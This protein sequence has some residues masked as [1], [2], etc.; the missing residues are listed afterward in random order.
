MKYIPSIMIG[1]SIVLF[2]PTAY[3]CSCLS[4][5]RS[6]VQLSNRSDLVIRGKVMEYRWH[7]ND[8]AR[9]GRPLA[10]T[11][12][13]KEV[14]KG[15]T[16]LGKVTVWGDNGM[17][18]RPYVTQFPI[19]TEWI[20]ALSKDSWTEKGALAISVCGEH[21]LQVKG[22]NVVGK[23]T[24]GSANAKLNVMSFPDFRK[25]LKTAI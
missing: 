7:K 1:L 17:Q 19:G 23:V 12:E 6:F 10:M 21:W 8:P 24:N 4:R 13:V 15:G 14:Y 2:T 22:N 9:Q 16:K 3:A 25:L 5:D 20:L 11:V 18:C